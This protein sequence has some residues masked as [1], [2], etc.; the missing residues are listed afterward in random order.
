[1]PSEKVLGQKKAVV[2]DLVETLKSAKSG[3]LV[4][5]KGIT[6]EDDTKLRSD[7]RSNNVEYFVVKNTLLR[8]AANQ[9]GYNDLD[10]YLNGTSAFAVS[11]VD[12]MAPARVLNGFAKKHDNFTFKAGI[13]EGKVVDAQFVKSIAELPSKS[14]LVAM[15][16]GGLN[17]PITKF[18]CVIDAIA[19]SKEASAS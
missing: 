1:M 6:V 4:D 12:E 9:L 10:P 7:L 17:A 13:F 3:V 18:A 14:V 8:I 15:A 2:E 19:K 16:L 11:T 5:Y